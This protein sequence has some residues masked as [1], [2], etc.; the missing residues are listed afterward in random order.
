MK[1]RVGATAYF[2][3]NVYTSDGMTALFESVC[4]EGLKKHSEENEPATL[5]K[6]KNMKVM[7]VGQEHVGKTSVCGSAWC[8]AV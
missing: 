5:V 7:I 8:S 3:T 6:W 2:E 1:V 4:R